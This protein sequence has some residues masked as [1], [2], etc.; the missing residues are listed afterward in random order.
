MKNIIQNLYLFI[1]KT[2]SMVFCLVPRKA[3]LLLGKQIGIII[4]ILSIRK[5]VAEKNISIAFNHLS[6]NQKKSILLNCYKHF[7]MVLVDF[8]RQ[9]TIN[10]EN[11]DQYF[12]INKKYQTILNQSNGGCIMSAH[13]GNWE[14]ILP[15]MGFH[16][17]PM[18]T[19]M[20]E[21]SNSNVN[22][23]YI[24]MRTFPNIGLIW[25]KNALKKLYEAISNNKFIGLASDQNAGK[26][27]VKIKFF[28]EKSSF[29]KGAGIFHSRTNCNILIVFC[30]MGSD[31]KYHVFVEEIKINNTNKN[32]EEIIEEINSLY[33]NILTNKIKQYPHQYF[34]FHKKWSKKIYN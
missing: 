27:G 7:G 20:K 8:L 14:Y 17:F 10:R 1:F 5:N 15:F 9:Q 4:Y 19:V 3:A 22:K 29:P 12:V 23:F 28:G 6:Q 18:E 30:I 24:E 21:Q 32:E 13:I 25:K 11:L 31:Y 16:N 33:A 2:I 26:R 34:W